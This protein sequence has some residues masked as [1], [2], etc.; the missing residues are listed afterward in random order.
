MKEERKEK[1]N[2]G[3]G[4]EKEVGSRVGT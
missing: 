4:T 2:W 3:V 1:R